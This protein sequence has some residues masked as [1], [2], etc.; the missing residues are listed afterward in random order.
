MFIVSMFG[1]FSGHSRF[2]GMAFP[3]DF[4]ASTFCENVKEFLKK[5]HNIEAFVINVD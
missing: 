3:P 1:A 5:D 2:V 4:G